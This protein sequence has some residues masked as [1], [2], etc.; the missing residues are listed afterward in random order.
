MSWLV[1]LLAALLAGLAAILASVG[2]VA[3]TR[4]RDGRLALVTSALVL[5]A[6]LGALSFLHEVSPLY[7]QGFSVDPIPLALALG[8]T[9]LLYGSLFRR[10]PKSSSE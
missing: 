9:V 7:G 6:L 5:L 1:E 2:A 3:S 8:A 10:R 4:L